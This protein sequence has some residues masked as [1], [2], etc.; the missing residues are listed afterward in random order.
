MVI[1]VTRSPLKYVGGKSA[2]AERIVAAFPNPTA[3]DRYTEP[4][5]GAAHVF[6]AKLAYGHAEILN[7]LDDNLITFWQEMQCHAESMQ[8]RLANTLYSRKLYY[9]YYRSLFD[10]TPLSPLE[11]AIRYF[12]V[13][14]S[15]GTGWMRRSPVGWNCL[16]ENI[17]SYHSA[18]N[19]FEAVQER[20]HSVII[21]N[22]DVLATIRRY[23]SPR[24]LFYIDPPYFGTEHY[25]AA[26]RGGFPHEQMAALLQQVQGY[27]AL[28]YYPHPSID[29]WYP[30]KKWRRIT[31]QQQKHSHIQIPE[32]IRAT[33]LLLCNYTAPQGLWTVREEEVS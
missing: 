17:L 26:S 13:L 20:L 6:F 9:E 4:C 3:Y 23:D 7:D 21:D 2:S 16:P 24:T 28:S 25:Y 32:R 29:T 8:E 10:K 33:E 5:C 15:T 18:L 30:S 1:A 19:L 27:V 22:R 11:R 14:R 12:Y 31:W